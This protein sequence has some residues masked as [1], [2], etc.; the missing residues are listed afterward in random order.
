MDVDIEKAKRIFLESD[1]AEL[2]KE[3]RRNLTHHFYE[4]SYALNAYEL[5]LPAD[6]RGEHPYYQY[7]VAKNLPEFLDDEEIAKKNNIPVEVVVA[8]RERYGIPDACA[9]MKEALERLHTNLRNLARTASLLSAR[10]VEYQ[11]RYPRFKVLEEL[12]KTPLDD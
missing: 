3:W 6:Y 1:E 2:A 7:R 10:C 8:Y 12:P 4:E 9:R 5:P 11:D